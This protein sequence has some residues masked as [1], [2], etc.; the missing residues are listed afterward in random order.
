M[1]QLVVWKVI[2]GTVTGSDKTCLDSM[3]RLGNKYPKQLLNSAVHTVLFSDS[4][5][6]ERYSTH[7]VGITSN[8]E[9]P[10]CM[11]AYYLK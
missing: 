3:V 7:T 2:H 1:S 11:W 10:G 9:R 5:V 8:K 4:T 6:R